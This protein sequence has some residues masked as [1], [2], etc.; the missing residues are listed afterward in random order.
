LHLVGIL[1]QQDNNYL[2]HEHVEYA[3][4]STA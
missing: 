4:R 3:V 1:F 2:H